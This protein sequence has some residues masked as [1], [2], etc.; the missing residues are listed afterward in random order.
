MEETGLRTLIVT[1]SDMANALQVTKTSITNYVQKGAAG[2]VQRSNY[3]YAFTARHIFR[4]GVCL[5]L[6][7]LG[8]S[9]AVQNQVCEEV[10][11]HWRNYE[12]KQIIQQS[13]DEDGNPIELIG[14]EIFQEQSIAITVQPGNAGTYGNSPRTTWLGINGHQT[15]SDGG[16]M[17]Y[18]RLDDIWEWMAEILEDYGQPA[19][20][21]AAVR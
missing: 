21:G 13:T 18:V 11:Q 15:M 2:D 5:E 14:A 12:K 1:G 19:R 4:L 3:G 17:Y 9:R 10:E 6:Q 20:E 8:A 7:N 16:A